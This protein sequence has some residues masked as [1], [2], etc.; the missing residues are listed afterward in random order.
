[1]S[2]NYSGVY[3][4]YSG[5][6]DSSNKKLSVIKKNSSIYISD[7][8]LGRVTKKIVGENAYIVSFDNYGEAFLAKS[9]A[10]SIIRDEIKLGEN[11]IF[12]VKQLGRG[13]KLPKVRADISLNSDNLVLLTDSVKVVFSNKITD[14]KFKAELT[15]K[16]TDIIGD[17]CGVLVRT[18]ATN[19]QVDE[20]VAELDKLYHRFDLIKAS[21][22]RILKDKLLYRNFD[23]NFEQSNL[24]K[25]NA[26][27]LKKKINSLLATN[28]V[29]D[30][31]IELK[32]E[33]TEALIAVD[34]DSAGYGLNSAND[35]KYYYDTNKQALPKIIEELSLR[36]LS[37]IIM[38]DMLKMTPSLKKSF[39]KEL[40]TFSDYLKEKRFDVKGFTRLGLLE[41]SRQRRRPSLCEL[42][43]EKDNSTRTN[44]FAQIDLAVLE[45]ISAS[46]NKWSLL[47][48]PNNYRNEFIKDKKLI[49]TSLEKFASRVFYKFT[50][51]NEVRV[52]FNTTIFTNDD[53]MCRI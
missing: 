38:V 12:Q 45:I 41:M 11:Y 21:E 44:F 18:S 42:L 13:N 49:K 52:E 5:D 19:L 1:M 39:M 43:S 53:D 25:I 22:R 10:K 34:V 24:Q 17:N 36:N 15:R 35:D 33:K 32:I 50:D 28:V 29:L 23:L 31:K 8:L 51:V 2:F 14:E 26:G 20:L 27:L 4:L 3:H 47:I 7:I 37:G 6:F 30:N 40:N 16:F 48:I 46:E 9:D